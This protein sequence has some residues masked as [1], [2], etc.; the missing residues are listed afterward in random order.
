MKA[1]AFCLILLTLN[2][3][4]PR[5][6]HRG[7][8]TR[9][10]SI[11]ER[12]KTEAPDAAAFQ[13]VWRD[14]DLKA[15]ALGAGHRHRVYDPSLGVGVTSRRPILSSRSLDLGGGRGVISARI[16]T[17]DGREADLYSARLEEGDGPAAARRLGELFR[18]AE[19][20]RSQSAARPFALMGDL[21]SSPDDPEMR[22]FMD[23]L[24]TRDL[25]VAHGDEVCGRTLGERRVDYIL[26][27][28]DSRA[29]REAARAA[30]T[31]PPPSEEEAPPSSRFG[32]RAR[33]DRAF[34]R[35]RPA[36]RPEGRAEA[37]AEI[38]ERLHLAREESRRRE[39]SSGWVPLLGALQ[40]ADARA[41]TRRLSAV[42]EEVRSAGGHQILMRSFPGLKSLSP[43]LTP[44][45]L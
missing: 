1:S 40:A 31:D 23:L 43:S 9:R 7:W 2:V 32:L 11:L 24:E 10:E 26:I 27:P 33:L 45:A 29:P 18:L 19:F 14:G 15:L 36:G 28:Y 13:G 21:A 37:L 42:L 17:E 44:K 4:G 6:I 20:V 25:C 8:P 22:L 5:R 16:S 38:E 35:L 34:L 3:A 39:A 12:L 30:F 41:E